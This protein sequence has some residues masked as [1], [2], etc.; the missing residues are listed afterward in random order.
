MSGTAMQRAAHLRQA[1]VR[2]AAMGAVPRHA[3]F[4]ATYVMR[5]PAGAPGPRVDPS[6]G[7]AAP[8]LAAPGAKQRQVRRGRYPACAGLRC[9]SSC[10]SN[11]LSLVR[12]AAELKA[13]ASRSGAEPCLC[14]ASM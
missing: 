1:M 3:R 14:I 5:G 7:R 4:G 13:N 10:R 9:H 2:K 12:Q 6:A 11:L 8:P